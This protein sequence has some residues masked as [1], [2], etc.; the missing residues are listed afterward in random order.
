VVDA[1]A[2]WVRSSFCAEQTCVEVSLIGDTVVMRDGKNPDKPHVNFTR[3]E[4]NAFRADIVKGA[5]RFDG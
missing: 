1:M 4:W 3:A 2:E 5:F